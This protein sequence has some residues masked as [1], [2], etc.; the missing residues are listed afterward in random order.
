MVKVKFELSLRVTLRFVS[1][2]MKKLGLVSGYAQPV[3]SPRFVRVYGLIFSKIYNRDSAEFRPN[4]S[5]FVI[6]KWVRPKK[7]HHS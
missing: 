3:L 7:W 6:Q 2:I 1:N 4:S 5:K